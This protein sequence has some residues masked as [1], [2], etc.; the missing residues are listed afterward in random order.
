MLAVVVMRNKLKIADKLEPKGIVAG[1]GFGTASL[2]DSK[3]HRQI[4][5]T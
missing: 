3:R 1:R 5:R 2:V 4:E